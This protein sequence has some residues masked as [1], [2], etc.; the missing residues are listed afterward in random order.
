MR[1][2]VSVAMVLALAGAPLAAQVAAMTEDDP[3]IWLEDKDGAK[4]LA[5][6]EAENA[7]TLKRLQGDP[8]Y[9]TFYQEALAIAAAKD[10]IPMPS[11]TGGRIL[12]FWRDAEHPLGLLRSTSEADYATATPTWR[13]LIDFDALSRAEGKQWVFKGANCLQPEERLCLVSLSEGGE[14]AVAYREFDLE[15]GRFVSGGFTLP[16]SKQGAAWIDKDTLLVSRDWGAGTLTTSSYPFV[17]KMLKRGQPLTAATEVFRGQASDQLGTYASSLMDANGNRLVTIER[18]TAFFG[19]DKLVWTPAGVRKLDMPPRATV[20]GLVDG[21]VIFETSDDWGAIKAGS[22]AWAPLA[23]VKAGRFT[24]RLLWAPTDR[25]AAQGVATTRGRVIVTYIDNVRG[26][27]SVFAPSAEGWSQTAVPLPENISVGVVSATERS[28]RAYL[29]VNGFTQP[30]EL[31]VLEAASATPPRTIKTLPPK[32]DATGVAVEQFEAVSSDGTKVPYF[33]VRPRGAKAD[34]STPTLMTAYGGFEIARL[35]TYLGSTGKI[36][37]E[38]G[39][40]FVLANIRGGGEF[41]PA[42]HDA[43]RRTKRQVIYDDFAAIARDLFQRKITSPAKLGIY[44]GSNGGL[45]MGVQ[46]NQHPELWKAVAIQ[47]PLLD[48]LRYEQIAAGASWVDEY[49]SVSVPEERAFLARISPYHNLKKGVAYPE[50]YIWTTTKDDRVGP[51]H[52]RKFAARMKDLGL[53]YLFYE[54]TAGGHSGDADIEQGARLQ[55]LQMVY[56]AQKLMGP[57]ESPTS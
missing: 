11:Q 8:R 4:A 16:K 21:R 14:D 39:G 2:M 10:R 50:P 15:T 1:L 22:V 54:D 28:D 40:A 56:F 13:T 19:G 29:A 24:P 17:V 45:L 57:A 26:R 48:M 20:A 53:P 43:G 25:Q 18:R 41:G 6:V 27:A 52:A 49:G 46:F 38:R 44:G 36:W 30:T 33:V 5:W 9:Q 31:A 37:T 32:F 35:P 34:G 51:Q 42:W 3:H 23:E 12:N 55:A 7:P 47:V